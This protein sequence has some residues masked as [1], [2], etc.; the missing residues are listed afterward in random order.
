M[1]DDPNNIRKIVS[2]VT[3]KI[4]VTKVVGTRSVKGGRGDTF[5][6]FSAG[7]ESV[8]DD[9]GGPGAD[10]VPDPEEERTAVHQGMTM[11][12]AI[13]AA[14]LVNLRVAMVA[15]DAAYANGTIGS[16]LYKDQRDAV[17]ARF[18]RLIEDSAKRVAADE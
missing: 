4:R 7:W 16:D 9:C 13:L 6:G 5:A 8:Q 11:N 14:H 12:E 17:K 15:L 2:D 1:S 18:S 10:L 3:S